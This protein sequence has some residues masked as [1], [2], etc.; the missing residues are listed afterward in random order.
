MTVAVEQA[1]GLARIDPPM[2]ALQA[3][4]A[5]LSSIDWALDQNNGNSPQHRGRSNQQSDR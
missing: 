1:S 3:R 2:P 5:E 4:A